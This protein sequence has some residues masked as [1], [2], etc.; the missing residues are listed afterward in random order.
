MNPIAAAAPFRLQG[1]RAGV[2]LC[3]GFTGSPA[4]MRPWAEHLAGAHYGV[5]VPLLPGHGTTWRHLNRTDWHDWYAAVEK[6]LLRM[7]DRYN[8]VVVGGLSMGGCLALRLAQV[9]GSLVSGLLLVNPVISLSDPRLRALPLLHRLV[10]SLKGISNDIAK[11][12]QD[13][14]AYDRT[15]LPALHSQTQM[16][17]VVKRDLPRVT[18]PIRLFQSATDHVLDGSSVQHITA[19]V[20]STDLALIPL[21]NSYHVATLDYDAPRIYSVSV[22]FISGIVG[23]QLTKGA[24]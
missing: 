13:E 10:P 4:S 7:A 23:D 19:T 2:V 17:Q 8:T 15:P 14:V 11:P 20:S 16:W 12:G 9:H 5:D 3:H 21:P 24:K 1:S 18:Q 6:S 22:E